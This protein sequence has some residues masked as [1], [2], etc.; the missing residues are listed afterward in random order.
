MHKVAHPTFTV[1]FDA[2][3]RT[4]AAQART[5]YAGEA[6]R[7]E[8]GLVIA[9]NGGVSLQSDGTALV[10]SQ[11]DAEV[12][13]RVN[14]HCDCP[15]ASR[16]PEGRCKHRWATCLTRR[17]ISLVAAQALAARR[18]TCEPP[19]VRWY[20]S[21]YGPDGS[22]TPGTAQHVPGHGWL[23]VP[24]D[25]GEPIYA[26]ELAL[27]RGGRVDL[28]EAQRQADGDLAAKVCGYGTAR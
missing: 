11:S 7:I 26:S 15:D 28:L 3:I 4:L 20:A 5:R 12:Q 18:E 27:V 25:G 23:F 24:E 21:Y 2:A 17:A 13:Y 1:Q 22:C 10:Q 19:P 8:R 16:A 14:G 6:A 9:L